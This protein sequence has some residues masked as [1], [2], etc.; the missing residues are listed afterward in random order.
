MQQIEGA[1]GQL[2]LQAQL[3]VQG[4]KVVDQRHDK[5]LAVGHRTGHAQQALGFAGQVADGAQGFFATVLQALAMLQKRLP[6]L[7]QADFA[8]AA[9]EQAG[10][11]A[12][13]QA[14]DLAADLR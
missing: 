11:Q 5:P 13:F 3:R 14:C 9:I 1:V 2:D 10:L 6:G 4:H 12:L 8:G 7:G